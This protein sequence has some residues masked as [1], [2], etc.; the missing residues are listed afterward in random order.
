MFFFIF[1]L[2]SALQRKCGR[3]VFLKITTHFVRGSIAAGLVSGV[4]PLVCVLQVVLPPVYGR[5]RKHSSSRI[6]GQRKY[7]DRGVYCIFTEQF[8][9]ALDPKKAGK[10]L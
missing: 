9:V 4:F 8:N 1:L 3:S 7:W 10:F 5:Q 6:V 2:S